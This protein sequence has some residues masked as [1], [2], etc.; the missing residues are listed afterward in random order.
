[1]LYAA[2]MLLAFV[3]PRVATA[4]YIGVAAMWLIP[5]RRIEK[6]VSHPV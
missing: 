2:A 3:Q 4:I 1:V 6:H 5:D